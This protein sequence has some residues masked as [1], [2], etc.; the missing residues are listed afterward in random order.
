[1]PAILRRLPFFNQPTTV[2]VGGQATRTRPDQIILWVSVSP[3]D[4]PDW[5]RRLPRLPTIL[6]TGSS[7]SFSVQEHH[8]VQWAGINPGFLTRL[9]H[10][11]DRERRVPLH[12][13]AVWIHRNVPGRR[14]E[15]AERPPLRLT[16]RGGLA[17]YPDDGSNYPRLP[18]LGLK[19]LADNHLH[20][21]ISGWRRSVTLRTRRRWWFSD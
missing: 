15:L 13:G 10:L 8:L 17:V 19:A 11:R 3:E 14:D 5:D 18:L 1:M 9:G 12:A 4:E 2:T 20:V 6:D 7:W 21:A 16:L